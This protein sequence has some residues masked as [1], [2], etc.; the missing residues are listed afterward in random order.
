MI[1]KVHQRLARMREDGQLMELLKGSGLVLLF[2][3][4]GALSGYLFTILVFRWAG[5]DGYG[6]FEMGFTALMIITVVS[7]LGL[8]SA[9]VKYVSAYVVEKNFG[10]VVR[11]YLL[12][13]SV[14]LSVSLVFAAIL[15]FSAD[16]LANF[17]GSSELDLAF[18]GMAYIIPQFA[19][20]QLNAETLRGLKRMTDFSLL[21][22]GSLMILAVVFFYIY[23][24]DPATGWDAVRAFGYGV[25][26]LLILS[27]F[28]IFRRRATDLNKAKSDQVDFG[29]VFRTAIPMLISGSLFL[30][31]SWTDTLMVGYFMSDA[32]VGLYR[33]VFKMATLITFSQFAINSI[34]A[35]MISGFSAKSDVKGLRSIIHQIAWINLLLSLPVFI[36]F[37]LFPTWVLETAGDGDVQGGVLTLQVLAIGQ[38]VN[39]L[40]GPVM[41]TLNMSGYE[42]VSQR[43]MLWTA[44]LN[45]VA[46]LILIPEM[47]ILGAA[48]ATSASMVLWNVV[49]TWKVFRIFRIISLPIPWRWRMK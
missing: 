34:A 10:K 38:V 28:M 29:S 23:K 3:I 46:N 11:L 30:V 49:A 16:S 21:Q 7:R 48:I 43:I 5:S 2:K 45:F 18:I 47:G 6:V 26:I 31:M 15:Y 42:K 37:V 12:S 17:F 22:N 44:L 27:F 13:A 40:C 24:G 14:V 9:I 20:L 39:A 41:Y 25:D 33:F 8:E 4:L 35:P 32:D 36:I 19:L 1:D